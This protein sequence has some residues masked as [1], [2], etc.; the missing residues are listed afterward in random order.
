MNAVSQQLEREIETIRKSV[1]C[2]RTMAAELSAH[3]QSLILPLDELEAELRTLLGQRL[4]S[5]NRPAREQ[6]AK[7]LDRITRLRDLRNMMELGSYDVQV[8]QAMQSV[9]EVLP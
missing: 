9:W 3:S 2:A 7:A 5:D 4:V 6:V 8:N 1:R